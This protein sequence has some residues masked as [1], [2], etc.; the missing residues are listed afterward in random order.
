MYFKHNTLF[1]Y[2][3]ILTCR[4]GSLEGGRKSNWLLFS[5]QKPFFFILFYLRYTN[6]E[7]IVILPT[8]P[9]YPLY[10][11]NMIPPLPLLLPYSLS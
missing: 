4:A 7:T 3:V 10:Y 6:L 1:E 11:P 2:V 8:L 5:G 9:P